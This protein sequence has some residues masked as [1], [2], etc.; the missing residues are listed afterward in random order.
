MKPSWMCIENIRSSLCKFCGHLIAATHVDIRQLA[1]KLPR[2][3]L[4]VL[5]VPHPL[6]QQSM[7][8]LDGRSSNMGSLWTFCAQWRDWNGK[9]NKVIWTEYMLA[10]LSHKVIPEP[11][12]PPPPDSKVH[13]VNMG[14]IW[15]RQNS[16]GPHVGPMNFAIWGPS[17]WCYRPYFSQRSH[18]L[19]MKAVWPL[20]GRRPTASSYI[21]SEPIQLWYDDRMTSCRKRDIY[22][23][24]KKLDIW[25]AR[26]RL[27]SPRSLSGTS[28]HLTMVTQVNIMVM[29]FFCDSKSSSFI[30]NRPP[31]SWDKAISDSDLETPR[32]RSWVW[33]KGKVI[34]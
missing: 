25:T 21:K 16:G 10:H 24:L 14:P 5:S 22:K 4:S 1:T 17:F 2:R 30:V 33:S 23:E 18:N 13:G 26:R 7:S 32:S 8:R 28:A 27:K 3:P 31:H 12:P 19:Q 34:Q 11:P 15:G 29:I 20:A 6:P 9:V